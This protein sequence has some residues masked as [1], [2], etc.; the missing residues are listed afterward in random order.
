[1][2]RSC[3]LTR[4]AGGSQCAHIEECFRLKTSILNML[5]DL[6]RPALTNLQ[7]IRSASLIESGRT[8]P[9]SCDINEHSEIR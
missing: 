1:M 6:Q 5:Q 2:Q 9:L 7:T 8:S 3:Y 4:K